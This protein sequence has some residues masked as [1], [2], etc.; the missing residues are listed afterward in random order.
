MFPRFP[1]FSRNLFPDFFQPC[2][3][4]E[5]DTVRLLICRFCRG[6]ASTKLM[7]RE[8]G[9]LLVFLFSTFT[10]SILERL[11]WHQKHKVFLNAQL[12]HQDRKQPNSGVTSFWWCFPYFETI[13]TVNTYQKCEKLIW[14]QKLFC[15]KESQGFF[16]SF[17]SLLVHNIPDKI[18]ILCSIQ[19]K[20]ESLCE[21]LY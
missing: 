19:V 15:L 18:Y 14:K 6:W 20:F 4:G 2:E 5:S 7:V 8:E 1:K 10:K 17:R 13:T 12:M 3:S 9:F 16:L 21:E 11:L